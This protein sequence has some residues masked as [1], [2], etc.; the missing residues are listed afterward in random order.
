MAAWDNVSLPAA[1]STRDYAPP[2]VDFSTIG[3]LTGLFNQGRQDA[4]NQR[5]REEQDRIN[6]F[7]QTQ[8]QREIDLQR[9]IESSDPRAV[10]QELMRRGG[11]PYAAQLFPFLQQQQQ[12]QQASSVSPLLGGSQQSAAPP[13]ASPV[14]PVR[15]APSYAGGDPGTG[16][17]A[18]IVGGAIGDG[19]PKTGT[20]IDNIARSVGIDPNAPL[21]AEQQD[22]VTR[23]VGA[24]AERA[25]RAQAPTSVGFAPD[26]VPTP[27]TQSRV[28]A[29]NELTPLDAAAPP[30]AQAAGSAP[31]PPAAS[32]PSGG[33]SSD[34]QAQP[35][36]PVPLPNDPSTGKPFANPEDAMR[37]LR[38]EAVRLSRNPY[39]KEQVSQLN[40]WADRIE[41]SLK[42]MH[43]GSQIVVP[44]TGKVM[45][46]PPPPLTPSDLQSLGW[47]P[48]AI[49]SAAETFVQTGKLPTNVGTR[50]FAGQ[51]IGA[52]RDEATRV[53]QERGLSNADMSAGWQRYTAQVAGQRVLEQRAANLTL[54][55]NE[56]RALIPRVKEISEKISKTEYPDLNRLILAA[57]QKTGNPDVVRLGI[58]VESLIPVYARILKPSGQLAVA[59]MQT[60]HGIL[61]KA[62]SNGQIDA[63]LDQMKIELDAAKEALTTSRKEFLGG[64][65]KEAAKDPAKPEKS[66][67]GWTE[68]PGGIKIRE[69]K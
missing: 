39:N 41:A 26:S 50:Q 10:S 65:P 68:L 51:I 66:E 63:A 23:L 34:Q 55:E 17:V 21:N 53:Q 32:S 35:L 36:S 69:K 56:A 24:Y 57:K 49:R 6:A 46:V 4:F 45:Q 27:T 14:P 28:Y 62:W 42:P 31:A 38:M 25:R 59:D 64:H 48:D 8:R 22:R 29:Q 52:I 16:T 47:S 60:A 67:G 44:G 58:A 1:P 43:V 40:A 61:D 54:A 13:S 5:Q 19:N 18:S 9:P 33:A 20:V 30:A 11:A 12:M 2:I 7:Q 3:N 15:R 37:A